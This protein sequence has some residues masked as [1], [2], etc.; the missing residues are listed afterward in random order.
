MKS[1][2]VLNKLS[3][4]G[5]AL[6][7]SG[8]DVNPNA[9]FPEGIVVRSAKVNT[10]TYPGL[11]AVARA[12]AG[13]NNIS[14]KNAT[15]RGVCVFNT[16]G[17]NANA[18]AELVFTMLG[19]HARRIGQAIAFVE[20]LAGDDAK[21]NATVEAEKSQFSGFELAGKT[22]GVIGLGKI[23]VLIANAGIEKGMTVIGYDAHPTAE[24]ARLLRQKVKIATLMEKVICDADILTVHVPLS[25]E[26]RKMIGAQQIAIMKDGCILM[27]YSRDGIYNNTAVVDALNAG[28]V[29]AYITDFPTAELKQA[30]LVFNTSRLICTPHLG[31]STEEAEDN[32][33]VMAVKQLMAYLEDGT[34]VNSVNFPVME[35]HP[36][37]A[38]RTR[39]AVVNKDVPNMISVITGVIGE[40]GINIH[41]TR[42]ESN[43]EVGY[44][45]IDICADVGEDLIERI[46]QL[47]NVIR[48]RV[49]KF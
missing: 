32:C 43:G 7:G 39:L 29:S 8:F 22:L 10:D 33:A 5:L 18:V 3:P 1:I 24:N 17:A 48:V 6:F 34:V 12:G 11:L 46:R 9:K 26:T 19:F 38:V 27:N 25:D 16:P 30:L 13:T 41:S 21:I 40:A 15:E 4:E 37:P 42:N 14:V 20:K 44:N 45:L 35:M 36:A 47:P 2:L 49:I 31:A 28:K 23:G